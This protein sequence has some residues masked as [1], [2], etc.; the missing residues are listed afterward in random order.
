MVTEEFSEQ[1]PSC[2]F[3]NL[4]KDENREKTI[5]RDSCVGIGLFPCL[6][7]WGADGRFDSLR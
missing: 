4:R 2:S 7:V 5:V 1:E 3:L 6:R